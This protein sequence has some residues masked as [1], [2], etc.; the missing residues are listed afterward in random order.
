MVCGGF[1][2]GGVAA[3]RRWRLKVIVGEHLVLLIAPI[4]LKLF[5]FLIIQLNLM[6]L[7]V[8]VLGGLLDLN[9]PH[10]LRPRIALVPFFQLLPSAL[11]VS[12]G[13]GHWQIVTVEELVVLLGEG[14]RALLL[15]A[16]LRRV[17]LHHLAVAAAHGHRARHRRRQLLHLLLQQLLLRLL[18][19][20]VV[21]SS[22]GASRYR[23]FCICRFLQEGCLG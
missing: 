15:V 10:H 5:V 6:H 17:L 3:L 22:G 14:R 4:D 18:G 19:G 9:G 7:F 1:I 2:I 16:V 21:W 11:R 12:L 23:S 8:L 20:S 13:Q